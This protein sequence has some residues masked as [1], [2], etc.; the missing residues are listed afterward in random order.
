MLPS[1]SKPEQGLNQA[2][3]ASIELIL[4]LIWHVYGVP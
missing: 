4:A 3:A 2:D 1:R